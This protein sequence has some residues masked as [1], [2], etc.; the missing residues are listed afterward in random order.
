MI[1]AYW[2]ELVTASLLGTD[3]RAPPTAPAGPLA[4]AVAD[5]AATTASEAMLAAV[6]CA[7]AARRGGMRPRPAA[8]RP[9]EP[10]TDDRPMVSAAAAQRWWAIVAAWPVLED[11]WLAEVARRGRRLPP[12]VLV[13]LLRRHRGAT[14]QRVL[15]LGGPLAT[16]LVE[17]LP[18]LAPQPAAGRP[19]SVVEAIPARPVPPVLL[20]LLAAP[21]LEVVTAV[22][23]GLRDG[24]FAAAHRA[25]L[26]N[27]VAQVRADALAPL[28]EALRAAADDLAAVGLPHELADL[29]ET[30]HLMLEELS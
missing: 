7:T 3:R 6:A 18:Q 25:V 21:P 2:Q 16:W 5:A 11:E 19:S 24:S 27:F 29:A 14:A 9:R 12:D 8:T 4:D 20:G 17:H 26:V 1:A 28:A 22:V 15:E 23:G 13:A 10:E 30:R